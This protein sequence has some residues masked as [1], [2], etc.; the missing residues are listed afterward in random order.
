[1]VLTVQGRSLDVTDQGFLVNAADWNEEVARRLA[2]S[3]NIELDERHWEI[4]LFIR[5]YYRQFK[6]LPN[7][8][9]FTKA[10]AKA[11]GEEKGN[12]RYLHKLFP[13]GPLKYACKLA[14]LPKPPTC[15]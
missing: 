2:E 5:D 1:M 6:H 3:D 11:L 14:G 12:S 10:V 9:V 4:I 7:A 13:E 8:R 15:L